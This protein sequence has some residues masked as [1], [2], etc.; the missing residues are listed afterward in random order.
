MNSICL[1]FEIHQPYRLKWFWPGDQTEGFERYF[2]NNVN[3]EIFE[4]VATKCYIP[5]NRLLLELIDEHRN[6]F[7]FS[8][9]ITGTL[10]DQCEKWGPEVLDT[11]I[12]L[13]E[14]GSVEFID[15]TNYHS[16]SSLFEDRNEFIEEV[17]QHRDN[18]YSQFSILPTTFR[19]TELIYNNSIAETVFDM[20]Y[21]CILAEGADHIINSAS[22][23][24][25]SFHT[26]NIFEGTNFS[27]NYVY[28]SNNCDIKVLLRNYKLS[29]DIGY[30]FSSSSWPEHPLTA[31]KWANWAS[32][33]Q[34]DTLNIFMDYETF[35]EHQW[36]DTGI[37]EFLKA[38]PYEIKDNGLTF[39]TP[40]ET[41]RDYQ[42]VGT[43]DIGDYS[44]TSWADIERD[45]SAWIGNDMQL[46]CFEEARL[47]EPYVKKT[48]D[49][50]LIHIWKHFL[51]SDHYYY[52]STK[53][54][55]DAD[56]HSYFSIHSSP[57]DASINFMS[58][59]LDFKSLV[60]RTL[61]E[62]NLTN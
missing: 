44:T 12:Q 47:I 50:N 43:I 25:Q 38:Y 58:A 6:E 37:F 2:D 22:N 46:R 10:L 41:I 52:M 23:H 3:K 16:I 32:N 15:E 28:K 36:A 4:K 62:K 29:D 51:T 49:Q 59:F 19:N 27:P 20:G 24:I 30:R 18:I 45:T 53:W 14:S 5:A 40:S 54:L 21:N 11:F 8:I 1:Y 56:V 26:R 55:D 34:G 31:E 7:K 13:A 35:G 48:R 60:F 57:Y 9:S 17:K 61:K 39:K 33:A 42:P